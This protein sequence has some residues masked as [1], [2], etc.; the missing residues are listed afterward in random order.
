MAEVEEEE[1]YLQK[2]HIIR[3]RL[4]ETF[5]ATGLS[6]TDEIAL[7]RRSKLP[8]KLTLD[9]HKALIDQIGALLTEHK[10]LHKKELVFFEQEQIQKRNED[11]EERQFQK[12][13]E[14]STKAYKEET[15]KRLQE[16]QERAY[17]G[18]SKRRE[19]IYDDPEE[20]KIHMPKTEFKALTFREYQNRHFPNKRCDS[21]ERC[22]CCGHYTVYLARNL[23][24]EK[25]G[26]AVTQGMTNKSLRKMY[27]DLAVSLHPDKG[28]GKNGEAIFKELAF[29]DA[30]ALTNC[31]L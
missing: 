10:A 27:K 11:E 5:K 12:A 6:F 2:A 3:D 1:S 18:A 21:D 25:Y 4:E 29:C 30:K 26:R 24:P 13:M 28:G 31:F 23:L 8:N 19:K 16:E 17:Q 7:P 22:H 20:V 14:L 9:Q 15:K